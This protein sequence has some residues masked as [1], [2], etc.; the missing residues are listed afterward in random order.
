[1]QSGGGRDVWVEDIARTVKTRST[2]GSASAQ[3]DESAVWSPDGGRVAYS[4]VRGGKF[5][6]YQKPSDGSSNEDVLLETA[7]KPRFATDW[8]PDGKYL[9]Y[10]ELNQGAWAIWVLPLFGERKSYIFLQSPTSLLRDSHPMANGLLIV[11]R[12]PGG[13]KSMPCLSP[14]RAASGKSPLEAAA[15]QPG[16][17]MQRR[18]SISRSITN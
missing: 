12:N 1:V 7:E 2:F 6:L 3:S 9:A 14:D 8:S 18:F 10:Y 17:A 5:G 4:S 13:W 16:D 11:R 15:N